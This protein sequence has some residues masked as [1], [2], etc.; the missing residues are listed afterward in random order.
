MR[1][2]SARRVT[3]AALRLS[4]RLCAALIAAGMIA[5]FAGAHLHAPRVVL[6]IVFGVAAVA[7]GRLW[8]RIE[9]R[10]FNRLL[11]AGFL[12]TLLG[13]TVLLL[14]RDQLLVYVAAILVPPGAAA[15]A[16]VAAVGFQSQQPDA[17]ARRKARVSVLL[18]AVGL[19]V[20]A[21]WHEHA[22][23]SLGSLVMAVGVLMA[24]I[25]TVATVMGARGKASPF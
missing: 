8:G 19:L 16:A 9:W 2:S 13:T 6:L 24:I 11:V 1:L 17:N 20:A 3:L 21:G 10:L 4:E 7:L 15:A 14:A 5:G 18:L 23:Q 25:S 22:W 12:L